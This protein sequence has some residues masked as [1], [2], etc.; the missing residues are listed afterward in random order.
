MR[1]KGGGA[2]PH[3]NASRPR[4]NTCKHPVPAPQH[5]WMFFSFFLVLLLGGERPAS[6]KEWAPRDWTDSRT[7]WAGPHGGL[8]PLCVRV[9]GLGFRVV[10]L[11]SVITAWCR[12]VRH[13]SLSLSRSLSLSLSF[14]LSICG[15]KTKDTYAH[16]HK[17]H[18][19]IVGVGVQ[20]VR[21]GCEE[22][23]LVASWARLALCH[24]SS[25]VS[26]SASSCATSASSSSFG[27]RDVVI[28][29]HLYERGERDRERERE[30]K[31]ERRKERESGV[32][33]C[34]CVCVL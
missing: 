17:K 5:L 20:G 8:P 9:S 32:C 16:V 7:N 2:S 14:A 25:S 30:R 13:L 34:V 26:S 10:G 27:R 18:T 31:R 4:Y 24:V 23:L 19:E 3:H 28:H 21:I 15:F 11:G 1:G 6:G 22:V 12:V 33:V 29:Q